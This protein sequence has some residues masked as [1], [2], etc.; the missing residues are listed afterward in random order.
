MTSDA[1]AIFVES[2]TET[3]RGWV[4]AVTM[5]H[6]V[7]GRMRHRV[8]LSWADHDLISGGMRPPSWTVEAALGVLLDA[9]PTVPGALPTRFDISTLR[10]MIDGFDDLV[11]ARL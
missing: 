4:Y 7:H 1:S 11:R 3:A 2:E 8:T 6:P 10:R 5:T 9:D